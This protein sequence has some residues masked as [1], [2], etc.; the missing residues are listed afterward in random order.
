[1]ENLDE[2]WVCEYCSASYSTEELD[3][4][5]CDKDGTHRCNICGHGVYCE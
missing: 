1:M 5:Q 3:N 2:I 4:L